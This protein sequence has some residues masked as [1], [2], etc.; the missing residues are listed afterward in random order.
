MKL[1]VE[2]FGLARRL[3]KEKEVIVE[4]S[5][6]ATLRD[7]V[8]ALTKKFP[9]FLGNLVVPETYDLKAPYF[10]NINAKRV[11]RSLEERPKEEER[12]L[13]MFVEAGG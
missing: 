4:L 1:T 13:L 3:A 10:F 11:A 7:V 2:L 8:V 5:D 6:D 9:D 12:L